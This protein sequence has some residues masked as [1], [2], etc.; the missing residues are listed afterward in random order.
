M[1]ER[2]ERLNGR[3]LDPALYPADVGPIQLRGVGKLLLG[4][5]QLTASRPHRVT[6]GA[7][8]PLAGLVRS[9]VHAE[10]KG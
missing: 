9:S 1:G 5:L 10:Q 8:L 3:I 2:A 6:D 4:E 7:S